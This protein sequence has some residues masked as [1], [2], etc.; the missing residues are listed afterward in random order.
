MTEMCNF[1]QSKAQFIVPNWGDKVDYVTGFLVSVRQASG[2]V[3]E[4]YAIID[5]ILQ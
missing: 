3:R 5:F 1:C 4:P 2:P